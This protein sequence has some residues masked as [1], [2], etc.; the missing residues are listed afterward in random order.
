MVELAVVAE[1]LGRAAA[2]GPW[3]TTAVVAGV[4]AAVGGAGLAKAL[5]PGLADGSLTAILAVPTAAPD[6]SPV[7]PPACPA[8]PVPTARWWSPARSG[9][10]ST[11]RS[12]PTHWRR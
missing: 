2:V 8:P 7:A 11:G 3:D 1:E 10:W 6:G 5:L 9:R 4:V 12:S